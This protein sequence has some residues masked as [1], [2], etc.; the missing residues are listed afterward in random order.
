[1]NALGIIE[2]ED[3]YS[4]VVSPA[5]YIRIFNEER[6]T[7]ERAEIIP[8]RLGERG[9]GKIRIVRTYPVRKISWKSLSG[10]ERRP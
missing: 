2:L 8:A 1:M 7:I 9:F 3:L 10:N 4:E 6:D 5:E